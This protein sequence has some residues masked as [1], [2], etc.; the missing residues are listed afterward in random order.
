V[1]T[2]DISALIMLNDDHA[3]IID[4]RH[5]QVALFTA[6]L[7]TVIDITASKHDLAL[8]EGMFRSRSGVV[9][10]SSFREIGDLMYAAAHL[11]IETH[12]TFAGFVL[13]GK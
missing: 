4:F 12:Q 5:N 8:L 11:R 7:P 10:V 3:Q 1:G 13:L 9:R 2:N 6:K